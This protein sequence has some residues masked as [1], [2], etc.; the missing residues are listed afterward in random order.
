[1]KALTTSELNQILIEK[2]FKSN[3]GISLPSNKWE[4]DEFLF[5]ECSGGSSYIGLYKKIGSVMSR[6]IIRYNQMNAKD[7]K[8]F[9]NIIL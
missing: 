4:A 3:Q 8:E 9:V 5:E 7:K 2:G 6:R 1:M